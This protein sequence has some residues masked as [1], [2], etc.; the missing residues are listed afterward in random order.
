MTKGFICSIVDTTFKSA[1]RDHFLQCSPRG[2]LYIRGDRE[3]YNDTSKIICYSDNF[4][5]T[6]KIANEF[7]LAYP[8]KC[9]IFMVPTVKHSNL[10]IF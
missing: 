7:R 10:N 5:K 1:F 6:T 9:N 8:L 3:V 4:Q 2:D